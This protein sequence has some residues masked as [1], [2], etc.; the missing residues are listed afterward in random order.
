MRLG[1]YSLRSFDIVRA[2]PMNRAKRRNPTAN[3]A[4]SGSDSTL[5]LSP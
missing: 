3:G 4:A 5:V 2:A 1:V